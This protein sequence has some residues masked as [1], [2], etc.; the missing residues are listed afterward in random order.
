VTFDQ[1]EQNIEALRRRQTGVELVVCAFGILE[2]A[3]QPDRAVH[4]SG[5]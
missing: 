1:L 3:E 2:T 5:L 4:G